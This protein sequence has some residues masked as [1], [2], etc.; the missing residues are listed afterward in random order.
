M[1][2]NTEPTALGIAGVLMRGIRRFVRLGL[3]AAVALFAAAG[4]A[5]ASLIDHGITYTL[6]DNTGLSSSANTHNYTLV[7][8]G[9]NA[10][11]DTEKGRSGVGAIAFNK[12]SNFSS[13]AAP[14]G[15]QFMNGGMNSSGCN[16]TGN[17]FCFDKIV[18]P[19]TSPALAAN[20]SLSFDFSV[21]VS[22]GSLASWRPDF[23]I[24]WIGS[25]SNY[26]LVSQ[27][28]A[29]ENR[30]TTTPTNSVPE[31][32]TLALLGAGLLGLGLARRM[33]RGA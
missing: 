24:D 6:Y 23:K 7:I 30:P 16:G 17:F 12:P 15:Y 18:N 22:S 29:P 11:A 31:P 1:T 4:S 20:S 33:R 14:S 28:L 8:T 5:K 9:I 26:D 25:K 3:V 19:P 2:P 21:T 10:T 13:A 27:T 32:A